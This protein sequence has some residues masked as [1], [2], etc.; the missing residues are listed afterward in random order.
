MIT[1]KSIR[2][3]YESDNARWSFSEKLYIL[4]NKYKF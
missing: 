4:I 2:I 1:C 3:F